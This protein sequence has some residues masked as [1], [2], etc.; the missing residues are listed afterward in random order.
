MAMASVIQYIKFL[1]QINY[2]HVTNHQRQI[3]II[4]TPMLQLQLQHVLTHFTDGYIFLDFICSILTEEILI[5]IIL[6]LL[7]GC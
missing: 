5:L 7:H 1:L 6:I 2:C 3:T 4:F